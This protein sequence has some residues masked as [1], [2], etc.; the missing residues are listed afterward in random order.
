MDNP[1]VLEIGS[2][3]VSGTV[4]RDLFSEHVKYTGFVLHDVENVGISGDPHK[5]SQY[6][7]EHTYDAVF[8]VS[9]FEHLAMPWVALQEINKI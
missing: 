4:R 7:E 9:V 8:S 3:N 5:L 2:R 6:V 1:N